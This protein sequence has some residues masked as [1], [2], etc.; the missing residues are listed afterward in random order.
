MS[1]DTF[2]FVN[3]CCSRVRLEIVGTPKIVYKGY[4]RATLFPAEK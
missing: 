1:Y 4:N 2:L 3:R